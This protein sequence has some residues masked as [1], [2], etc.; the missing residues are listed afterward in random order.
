MNIT[1]YFYS[2]FDE[3]SGYEV[4]DYYEIR[5]DVLSMDSQTIVAFYDYFMT[6]AYG[7]HVLGVL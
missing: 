2:I 6:T 7:S 5:P 4:I 1:R 3:E